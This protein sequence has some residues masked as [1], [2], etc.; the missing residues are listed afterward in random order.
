MGNNST[1]CGGDQS[2]ANACVGNNGNPSY[3]EYSKGFST[4]AN[5]LLDQVIDDGGIHLYVDELIYPICF[6]MRHSVELRLKGAIDELFEIAAIKGSSFVFD[7]ATSHDIGIIWGAFKTESELLDSRYVSLNSEINQIIL[8]IASVDSTGQTFR[9][10]NSNESQ[11]HLTEVSIINIIVLKE[12]F[13]ELEQ[14]LDLLHRLNLWL[15]DEYQQG[16]HTSKL[17][18]P[19]FDKDIQG[20]KESFR[21]LIQ[22]TN[23]LENVLITLFAL[24][25][26]SL[27]ELL[28]ARYSFANNYYWIEKARSG[29]LFG[30][31]DFAGY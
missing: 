12:K 16:T 30:Y 31:P 28:I 17:S 23:A 29:E 22:K 14:S 20:L 1:F 24:G 13:A 11:K 7:S 4:A 26:A 27:A 15:R 9:Y 10:P 2:W 5:M 18:R 25:N 21:H 8:D 6:N 19:N 3:V